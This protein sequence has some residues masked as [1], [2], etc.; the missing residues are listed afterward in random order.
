MIY[1]C[2]KNI[3]KQ[4]GYI[5]KYNEDENKG[6]LV[7][8]YNYGPIWDKIKPLLFNRTNCKTVI[9]TGDLVYFDNVDNFLSITKASLKNFDRELFCNMISH[10]PN[11]SYNT[12]FEKTHIRYEDISDL[13]SSVIYQEKESEEIINKTEN[14]IDDIPSNINF[15]LNIGGKEYNIDPLSGNPFNDEFG[16]DFFE[17]KIKLPKDIDSLYKLFGRYRHNDRIY[18]YESN[19]S[20]SQIIALNDLRNWIDDETLSS[21]QY[22]GKNS[23]EFLDIYKLFFEQEKEQT[24]KI[25]SSY[26]PLEKL[27]SKLS[28]NDIDNIIKTLPKLQPLLP[29]HYCLRHLSSLSLCYFFPSK[30]V[31]ISFLEFKV[32]SINSTEAFIELLNS[33]KSVRSYLREGYGI[34]FKDVS[35]E[36]HQI[37]NLLAKKF[38]ED[39]YPYINSEIRH[40]TMGKI[41]IHPIADDILSDECKRTYSIGLF[42]ESHNLLISNQ[43]DSTAISFYANSI[44]GLHDTDLEILGNIIKKDINTQ[45][46]RIV[47][48]ESTDCESVVSI[49]DYFSNWIDEKTISYCRKTGETHLLQSNNIETLISLYKYHLLEEKNFCDR[50]IKLSQDLSVKRCSELLYDGVDGKIALPEAIQESIVIR[51][52][53]E[54]N[55]RKNSDYKQITLSYSTQIYNCEDLLNWLYSRVNDKKL[56]KDIFY[57]LGE[58]YTEEFSKEDKWDLFTKGLIY[59]PDT[60]ILKEKIKKLYIKFSNTE[61]NDYLQWQLD[62]DKLKQDN[63]YL[64]RTYAQ[65]LLCENLGKESKVNVIL[66]SISLLDNNSKKI[67]LKHG[68]KKL[69]F[70]IWSLYPNENIDLDSLDNYY[71]T[72]PI[73][74]QI[75]ILRYLFYLKAN[76]VISFSIE[77]LYRKVKHFDKEHVSHIVLFI[78]A[79]LY[80]NL[81]D[82]SFSQISQKN[83][84]EYFNMPIDSAVVYLF[85][86]AKGAINS[87]FYKCNGR[88]LVNDTI[89]YDE[90]FYR[91]G[92]I[93]FKEIN[94]K[95]FYV[96]SFYDTPISQYGED[97]YDFDYLIL[98]NVIDTLT[99]N[100][101]YKKVGNDYLID[102]K[103][104]IELM[105]YVR[106]Y[107]I[108]DKCNLFP[109]STMAECPDTVVEFKNYKFCKSNFCHNLDPDLKIPFTWCDA[110]PCTHHYWRLNPT[111]NWENYKFIDLVSILKDCKTEEKYAIY[112][113]NSEVSSFINSLY[114]DFFKDKKTPDQIQINKFES[115]K[116][117]GRWKQGMS[118]TT[119]IDLEDNEE[120]DNEYSAS[121]DYNDY[122]KS[123]GEEPTYNKYRGS[124]AQDE[125]G[126]SDDDIDTIFDGDPDAYWNI[127]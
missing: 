101:P 82:N 15:S 33:L 81:S 20:E 22:Y 127:D 21:K 3:M 126:Y 69:N 117:Q 92:K 46:K 60:D 78:I 85:H 66:F 79:A 54:A 90:K 44:D 8:G 94:K 89:S 31:L 28:D 13:P 93:E 123:S 5:Y 11:E 19:D 56:S 73:I 91:Y 107:H 49:C 53:K 86:E 110:K 29:E 100:F 106:Y 4:L 48:K 59:R 58:I 97:I 39:I 52:F 35:Q 1:F 108:D 26:S 16:E 113:K 25:D 36:L 38:N 64:A 77:D 98:D 61:R 6:I 121:N 115:E 80:Y 95:P 10:K 119:N 7:Y 42:I 2:H 32:N 67:I 103:Y 63:K 109:K 87:F 24:Q 71:D 125:M 96:V 12:Y 72:L 70:Y 30:K 74:I 112:K 40:L 45:L 18:L 47:N 118:I 37:W 23:Q 51:I 111:S 65:K 124:Y 83:M 14:P 41:K 75:R 34:Y 104:K 99:E 43:N 27:L 57:R 9:K 114:M 88:M 102:I 116:D 120:D 68:D 105:D 84:E 55:F 62:I 17:E 50:F 122:S 76:S